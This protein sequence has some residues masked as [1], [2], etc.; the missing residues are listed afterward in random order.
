MKIDEIRWKSNQG[1]QIQHCSLLLARIQR[2]NI[3]SCRGS[4]SPLK[5]ASTLPRN[6]P[7]QRNSWNPMKIDKIR[8]N[9][10][11]SLQGAQIQPCSLLLARIQGSNILSCRGTTPRPQVATASPQ[12]A[13]FLTLEIMKSHEILL[14]TYQNH[15]KSM[16]SIENRWNPMQIKPGSSDPALL[17]APC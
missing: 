5:A 14:K 1:A 2:S 16:K 12:A 4:R 7:N 17:L 8:C 15:L 11:R 3:L 9:P 6:L 10:W 13:N